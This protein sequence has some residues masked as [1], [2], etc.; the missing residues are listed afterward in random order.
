M[1]GY[2]VRPIE[3]SWSRFRQNRMQVFQRNRQKSSNE[4]SHEPHQSASF[5]IQSRVTCAPKHQRVDQQ[6][7]TMSA[8]S[9]EVMPRASSVSCN[10]EL[11][12]IIDCLVWS[13]SLRPLQSLPLAKRF[14]TFIS[15]WH[16][17]VRQS[18]ACSSVN[19]NSPSILEA[20][21]G[22]GGLCQVA[23]ISL[24]SSTYRGPQSECA[25]FA[26]ATVICH[27]PCARCRNKGQ[28]SRWY[29]AMNQGTARPG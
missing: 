21:F 4:S 24:D 20:P 1:L 15:S 12:T 11:K 25:K 19:F 7:L 29:M 23:I 26:L 13:I 18:A 2:W 9:L 27:T 10:L 6:L 3:R 5:V 28:E 14:E 22:K 17:S 16:N 8:N